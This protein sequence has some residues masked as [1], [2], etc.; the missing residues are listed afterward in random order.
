MFVGSQF[1]QM[2]DPSRSYVNPIPR[3]YTSKRS[4]PIKRLLTTGDLRL[5]PGPHD[6]EIR[7]TAL[8]FTLPQRVRFRYMLQG[9]DKGW[10]DP[11]RAARPSIPTRPGPYAFT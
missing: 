7:Y 11:G 4:S 3:L 2:I 6:I 10:Q 5:A 9:Q 8:S 1:V